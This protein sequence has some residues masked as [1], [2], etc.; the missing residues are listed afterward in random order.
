[1]GRGGRL[2]IVGALFAG[3]V[4]LVVFAVMAF[5]RSSPPTV[6]FT[7][8]HQPGTPVNLSLQTVGSIGFGPH[9]TWVSYL[10]QAPDGSWVHTTLWD[11]P[12]HTRINVTVHQYDS[13]SP[14]RNQFFGRVTGTLGG[15]ATLN[16][17]SFTVINANN[18]N[19]V[20]HTFA[21]PTLGIS[22]PLYANSS[23]SNLC[24]GAPC[25]TNS[26]HN[27]VKFSF[28]TPGPGQYPWQ[29]F[30]PCGLGFLYGNG[31]PMQ[32]IGYMDGFLK[33]VT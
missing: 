28:V 29:C 6:D 30:L 3:A 23:S 14:L 1:V 25:P 24:S 16:G 22:V 9:P 19:G 4:G 27:I 7:A 32:T 18:N 33:V 8:G 13:G 26:P 5:L 17:K 10:T 21:I 31:G 11:L 12:A 15:D 20:A 2:A